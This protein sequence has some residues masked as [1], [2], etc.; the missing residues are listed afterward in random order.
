MMDEDPADRFLRETAHLVEPKR[1]HWVVHWAPVIYVASL[2][3]IV[4]GNESTKGTAT[5]LQVVLVSAV[6]AVQHSGPGAPR[7]S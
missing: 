4:T 2:G 7:T 6:S 1:P 3:W 5:S